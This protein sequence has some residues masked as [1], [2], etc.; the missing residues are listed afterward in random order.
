MGTPHQTKINQLTNTE[1]LFSN[2]KILV[3]D[4]DI[5]IMLRI[6]STFD[7][8]TDGSHDQATGKL[9]YGWVIAVNTQV[10]ASGQGPAPS[11]P[12]SQKLPPEK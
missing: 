9:A 11:H 1:S 6:L 2:I 8:A 12:A 5:Q 7:V 10:I 4:E 3:E